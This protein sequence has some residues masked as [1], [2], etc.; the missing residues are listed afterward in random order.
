[1]FAVPRVTAIPKHAIQNASRSEPG[2]YLRD[3]QLRQHLLQAQ[4]RPG[5]LL[6][7]SEASGLGSGNAQTMP[8]F[9]ATGRRLLCTG[10]REPFKNG[11]ALFPFRRCLEFL[12]GSFFQIVTNFKFSFSFKC[13]L[14]KYN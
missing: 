12:S 11:D 10:K 14:L 8:F 4:C 7:N 5:T 3:G 13:C 9:K 1:M 2:K 6:M